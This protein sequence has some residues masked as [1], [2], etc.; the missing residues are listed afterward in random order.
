MIRINLI[1]GP[2][3]ISTALMYSFAQRPDTRVLDE[4]YYAVYLLRTGVPHPA[5]EAIILNLP[6]TEEKADEMIFG[7]PASYPVLF[8]KNM[9][10]HM[11]V[12]DHEV[13]DGL[14]NVFLIRDPRLVIASYSRIIDRPVM[15]DLGIEYQYRL[16]SRLLKLTSAPPIVIDSGLL[17]KSPASVLR[18]LC[19]RIRIRFLPEMLTWVPGPKSY[20]GIWAPHWYGNVHKSEG[21]TALDSAPRTVPDH[22]MPLCEESMSFYQ[23]L[24]PFALK[25][26]D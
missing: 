19:A 17:L 18:Q 7:Q 3:N 10:H 4:P 24:L 20:D 22:L 8:I 9:A 26:Q 13:K 16:F 5:R 2:R 6:Q 21:F 12:L 23:K 11:E 15:R 1:S 14:I 25:P